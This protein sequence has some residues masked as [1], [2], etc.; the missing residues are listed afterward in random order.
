[1]SIGSLLL[2]R[3]SASAACFCCGLQRGVIC[4]LVS[5]HQLSHIRLC[6]AVFLVALRCAVMKPPLWMPLPCCPFV[7]L[8]TVGDPVDENFARSFVLGKFR[9]NSQ[10][11][12]RDTSYYTCSFFA[13]PASTV[14]KG[15][16]LLRSSSLVR[17]QN[18]STLQAIDEGRRDEESYKERKEGRWERK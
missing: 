12:F 15:M 6:V 10:D 8:H 14:C 3:N 5:A 18:S 4:S 17:R 1:M 9:Y 7:F 11:G 2:F 16:L 13:F